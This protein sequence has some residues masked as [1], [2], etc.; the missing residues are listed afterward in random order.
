M[1]AFNNASLPILNIYKPLDVTGLSRVNEGPAGEIILIRG[2]FVPSISELSDPK[3]KFNLNFAK[4]YLFKIRP[5]YI[6]IYTF[7]LPYLTSSAK[8]RKSAKGFSNFNSI[9]F[10]F[11]TRWR[12]YRSNSIRFSGI[13]GAISR[14]TW[15]L[16]G[17]Y[18]KRGPRKTYLR[19]SLFQPPALQNPGEKRSWREGGESYLGSWPKRKKILYDSSLC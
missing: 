8:Y 6:Y 16:P 7:S 14:G 12:I 19:G 5:I 10:I 2:H 17:T 11:S 18:I 1:I 3:L 15:R 4:F 13:F 9:E